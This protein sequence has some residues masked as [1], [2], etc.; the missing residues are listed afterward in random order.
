MGRAAI[1]MA[2]TSSPADIHR[3]HEALL[4]HSDLQFD[5]PALILAEKPLWLLTLERWIG[6]ALYYGT[7][8]LAIIALGLILFYL[9][10]YLWN[11]RNAARPDTKDIRTAMAEWRPTTAQAR[12]LLADADALAQE[13]RFGEAVHILLLRSI[14]DLELFRPRVVQRAYT[15]REIEQLGVMPFKVREAFAGI[16][17]VVERSLFGG[18]DVGPE[19]FSR[20]RAEYERFAF[21]DA[22]RAG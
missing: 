18:L 5:F 17:Q 19:D 7:W 10:R 22:W 15:S 12:A 8:A 6:W 9:G 13:G 2:G 4:R 16:M 20:C 11:L 21:P 3:A 1:G 14:E